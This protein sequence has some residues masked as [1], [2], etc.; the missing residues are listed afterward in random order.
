MRALRG[1]V[2][3]AVLAAILL[4]GCA[5]GP[6]PPMKDPAKGEFYSTDEMMRLPADE[7]NRY[8][9][10]MESTL[11]DLKERSRILNKRADSLKVV[12]DT[13]RNQEIS[14]SS[15]TRDLSIKVR[16]LRLREKAGNTYVVAPGDNLRKIAR[17][18]YG[19][20]SRYLDIYKA[21]QAQIGAEDA[22]LKPGTK[23]T[24][25]RPKE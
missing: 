21:N 22:E 5:H 19:D 14:V 6:V 8:C 20:P 1:F 15:R 4:V 13:L 12:A 9:G 11:R 23:L 10:W 16:E 17:N 2:P 7:Q 25:P 24:I 18:V 3:A